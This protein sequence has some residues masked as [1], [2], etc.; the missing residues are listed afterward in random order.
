MSADA[1]ASRI[2]SRFNELGVVV[3]QSEHRQLSDY[4]GL[5]AKWNNRINLTA[6]PVDSAADAAIDRLLAEPILASRL[7]SRSDQLC[8]DLGSGGG[9]PAFPMK[10][11]A[12]WLQMV[13][14]ESKERKSAFLREVA[15]DLAFADVEVRTSRFELLASDP[16]IASRADIVSF[17]AVR[18]DKGLWE[19][20]AALLK[21]GGRVFWFGGQ[22]ESTTAFGQ[23]LNHQA[24]HQLGPGESSRLV[25]L[26]KT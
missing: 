14:V 6:L 11:G 13:L 24:T 4:F 19:A 26:K 5:L 1:L 16:R 8:V 7:V 3:S 25:V 18:A 23:L 2:S 12:P 9:S 17:R 10:V 21:S 20:V 22:L 15:R